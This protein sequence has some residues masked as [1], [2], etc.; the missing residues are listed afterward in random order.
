M[1]TAPPAPVS[2]RRRYE[3]L[4][5]LR[6]F[7]L[8]GVLLV[9]LRDFSLYSLL[10]AAERAAL[11]TAALDRVLEVLLA[12]L[13]DIKSATLFA[14]LFGVGFALQMQRAAEDPA[15]GQ[16]YLR[17]LLLL[18]LIGVAHAWLLWWGDILRYYA[19]LGL[20]LLPL[21]RAGARVLALAGVAIALFALPLL[22]PL[23][24]PLL[25]SLAPAAQASATALAAFSGPDAGAALVA[26]LDYDL[27]MRLANWSLAFFVL[28]RLLI[29]AALG[30][31]GVLQQPQWHRAFWRRLLAVCL[32]LGAALTAFA[33]LRDHGI[34]FADGW[35]KTP[36]ARTLSA[37]LRSAST[38]ALALGYMALVVT[39]F[40]TRM[41]PLLLPLIP[42]GRM[43]LSNYLGQTFIGLAVFYGAGLGL[44]PRYGLVGTL[45]GA[46]IIFALQIWLSRLWLRRFQFGPAE[47]LWRS[48][49]YGRRQP[50][51]RP[52]V[53]PA[54]APAI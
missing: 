50:L 30:F 36:A 13:V 53:A 49:T 18:V 9:N 32:P 35:W 42:V 46:V 44:G 3:E 43:A 54:S 23:V 7:A 8:F 5:A 22:R 17:R 24:V 21:G 40:E 2:E 38:L 52:A 19:V 26:N 20:L 16:R 33:L 4:D 12:A 48:L 31:A 6:G 34:A 47:W 27:R 37:T 29:G 41:R 11:P 25:P 28:G 51:L 10:P 15:V 1:S 14:M 45:L 39:A